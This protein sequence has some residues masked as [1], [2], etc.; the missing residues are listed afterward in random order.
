MEIGDFVRQVTD[1]AR[2]N[3]SEKIA[4]FGWFLH[5]HR[6]QE[7]FSAAEIRRC[8]DDVHLTPPGNVNGSVDAL[9]EKQ[10]PDLLKDVQGYRL[11]HQLRDRLDRTLGRAQTFVEV[12]KLLLDLPGK[13]ADQGE[14][15]FLAETLTCYRNGAFRAA[16]V[17]SWNLAYDHVAR[18]VLADAQ[19]LANFN[20][21]ISKRNPKKAHVVITRRED[22][23]EL[24][25]DETVDILGTLPGITGG[26]KR[27]LKEK[28]GRRNT[29]AHPSTLTVGRPHVDDMIFDLVNNV[30]LN[31]EL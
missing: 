5:T 11:A 4:L 20:A 25:E 21:G 9:T 24:K 16:I 13:I 2:K 30:V 18:W 31:L 23:E 12:E 19:R 8:Y 14:R 27:I 15:I 29:Y 22:F 26:M 1:F 3:H 17:M 28:L 6:G 10:P 7:R